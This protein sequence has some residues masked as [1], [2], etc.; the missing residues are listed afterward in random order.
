[1]CCVPGPCRR[2]T[3]FTR[4]VAPLDLGDLT[5]F[6]DFADFFGGFGRAKAVSTESVAEMTDTR[7]AAESS[8][9]VNLRRHEERLASVARRNVKIFPS[10]QG[11]GPR[12]ILKIAGSG[13]DLLAIPSSVWCDLLNR[14]SVQRDA[15]RGWDSCPVV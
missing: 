9:A 11:T 10:F 5:D 8:E 4:T 14:P 13:L 1:L 7:A 12:R 15:Q 3:V 2:C 6:E